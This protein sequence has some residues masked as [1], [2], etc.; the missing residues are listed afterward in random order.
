M[1]GINKNKLI[2]ILLMIFLIATLFINNAIA[3]KI[4]DE[5]TNMNS[6]FQ[7]NVNVAW[8]AISWKPDG[9]YALLVGI[10]S[11][12]VT[13]A[14]ARY[15]EISGFQMLFPYVNSR[16]YDAS[17]KPDGSY[18]LIAGTSGVYRYDGTNLTVLSSYNVKTVSWKPDG[19]YA[20]LGGLATTYY[21]SGYGQYR[22][23][24][25]KYD[26]TV[27]TDLTKDTM[28]LTDFALYCNDIAWCPDGSS[29]LIG[30]GFPFGYDFML[31]YDGTGFTTLFQD[32]PGIYPID[33]VSFADNPVVSQFSDNGTYRAAATGMIT[34]M[35]GGTTGFDS[36]DAQNHSY[37]DSDW[38]PIHDYLTLVGYSGIITVF[39]PLYNT[40]QTIQDDSHVSLNAIAW[41]ADGKYALVCGDGGTILRIDNEAP[42][43]CP[44]NDA[45][46]S[47]PYHLQ[48]HVVAV[49][50]E[51]DHLTYSTDSDLF[52]ISADG[53]VNFGPS[54][55]DIGN[56]S[57]RIYVSDGMFTI[58]RTVN[59][60]VGFSEDYDNDH[61]PDSWE[62]YYFG[63]F[64]ETGDN[65]TDGDGINN[66]YE[67]CSGTDPTDPA[68]VALDTDGDGQ[69]DGDATGSPYVG[70]NPVEWMDRDDDGDNVYDIYDPAPLDPSIT[71]LGGGSTDN[72]ILIMVSVIVVIIA[73][74]GLSLYL[75][76]R[77]K[78]PVEN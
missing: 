28:P 75:I 47:Y 38:H 21:D 53:Y 23:T 10:R 5:T 26:G 49:D 34:L 62:Y 60:S 58:N 65:D 14:I 19:S 27:F 33:S 67:Y 69:P 40:Y 57:F 22:P 29:A 68:S 6:I 13:G 4:V 15:D 1:N 39:D 36:R 66:Y 64:S 78:P 61:L 70:A 20:L 11:T 59:I 7:D 73:V 48:F 37:Y 45:A 24:V 55:A 8:Q 3:Y 16:L 32:R 72:T 25:I 35:I 44:I 41:H 46:T 18:A 52:E 50:P 56:H 74:I 63:N 51:G 31:K 12:N 71:G 54:P 17:W 42:A 9:S 77:K 30:G 76:K 2:A 43:I